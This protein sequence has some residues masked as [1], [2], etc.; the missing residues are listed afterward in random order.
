M[1]AGGCCMAG[2]LG[3]C[4]PPL[5]VPPVRPH[6]GHCCSTRMHLGPG[7]AN[8]LSQTLVLHSPPLP[9]LDIFLINSGYWLDCSPS[10]S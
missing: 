8:G 4:I 1:A 6:L 10:R 5:G 2:T 9:P 7:F 3:Q